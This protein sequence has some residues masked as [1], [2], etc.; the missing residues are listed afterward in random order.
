MHSLRVYIQ[1]LTTA[2]E[3]R[4]LGSVV[5]HWIFQPNLLCFVLCYGFHVVRDQDWPSRTVNN[6]KAFV[7]GGSSVQLKSVK[8]MLFTIMV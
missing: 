6:L 5:E 7:L 2:S 4:L 3:S 8:S 1:S